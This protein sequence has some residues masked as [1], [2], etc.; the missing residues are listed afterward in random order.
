[1]VMLNLIR[2]TDDVKYLPGIPPVVFMVVMVET[3]KDLAKAVLE[4]IVKSIL[5][6]ILMVVVAMEFS[7][8]L[9]D[10]LVDPVM[11]SFVEMV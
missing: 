3:W 7:E 6:A 9:V 8:I 4:V 5:D 1:M 2:H 10:E 11:K